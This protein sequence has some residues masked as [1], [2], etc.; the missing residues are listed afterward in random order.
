MRLI[1]TRLLLLLA[2]L[3]AVLGIF[4]YSIQYQLLNPQL[5]ED[6]LDQSGIFSVATQ[7]VEEVVSDNLIS[8]EKGIVQE[9]GKVDSS[10][11]D[12]TLTDKIILTLINSLIDTQT[13]RLVNTIMQRVD[14]EGN[15][16][17]YTFQSINDVI[18]FVNG[19]SQ[20]GEVFE[21]I[22]TPESVIAFRDASLNQLLY[23]LTSDRLGSVTLPVCTSQD[24]VQQNLNFIKEGSPDRVECTNNQ[25]QP[26]LDAAFTAPLV[27][28]A[29]GN[30]E[31]DIQNT[32]D[33]FGLTR[34]VDGIYDVVL[35]I[36]EFKQTLLEMQGIAQT[37]EKASYNLILISLITLLAGAMLKS[38]DRLKTVL[39]TSFYVGFSVLVISIVY[40]LIGSEVLVQY[41]GITRIKSLSPVLDQNQ[42]IA[43]LSSLNS[44][45]SYFYYH[46]IDMALLI[47][48]SLSVIAGGLLLIFD[49]AFSKKV[50]DTIIGLWVSLKTG[51][52]N[53][54]SNAKKRLGIG[55]NT[56]KTKSKKSSGGKK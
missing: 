7:I 20:P 45:V 52:F 51:A 29:I 13:P 46:V 4:N 53:L 54:Y 22:P 23:Q 56:K 16:R 33:D 21:K 5:Y 8:L 41:T 18:S 15:V 17:Q 19:D 32:F 50:Q 1:I 12:T 55:K 37:N 40:K 38:A 49:L 14:F 28:G 36:S 47:G 6:A 30:V 11:Q 42:N 9:V 10:D 34:V 44:A 3:T 31:T 27:S 25:I 2:F 26:L 35:K 39:K 48:F 43:L 24:D